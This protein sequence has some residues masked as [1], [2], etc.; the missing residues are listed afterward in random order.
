MT[1]LS[2]PAKLSF[3]E[4]ESR[5]ME[6]LMAIAQAQEDGLTVTPEAEAI[7]KEYTLGAVEKR[8]RM[9]GFIHACE[10]QVEAIKREVA[11]LERKGRALESSA[12]RVRA[13]VVSVMQA[14]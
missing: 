6:A 7:V 10:D 1:S 5:L 12:E 2:S 3:W 9:V 11:R 4:H 8:E 14:V 13:L